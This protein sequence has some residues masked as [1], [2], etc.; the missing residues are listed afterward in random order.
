[1]P[2]HPDASTVKGKRGKVKEAFS[3]KSDGKPCRSHQARSDISGAPG[4]FFLP[5]ISVAKPGRHDFQDTLRSMDFLKSVTTGKAG[6]FKNREP[7]KA[8][9]SKDSLTAIRWS[10]TVN[11]P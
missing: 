2:Q 9:C 8:V 3:Y 6:G 5:A 1:M 11:L 4:R 7:L 10:T